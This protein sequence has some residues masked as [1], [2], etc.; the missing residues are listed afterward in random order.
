MAFTQIS[1]DGIKD[2]T[3]SSADLADQSVTLAKLPHG[4]SSNDG[5]FLRANNGADPTFETVTSIGGNTGVDFNDNVKVRFGTG[6]DLQIYHDGSNSRIH[7]GGTGV[8]AISGSE[9]HIQNA[10]QSENCA[11]FIQNGAVELYHD[12]SK[13]FETTSTGITVSGSDTTGSIIQGDFRLKTASG[14][15]HIVYDA[16]NSRINFADNISATFGD[17][18]DLQIY[19]DGSHSYVSAS[20]TGALKL[21]GNNND[22]VQIQPRSG[23]NSARFKPNNAV[24]L[25]YDNSKK[26]ETKSD[27]VLV[28]GELQAT[29]LDIN[30]NGH[31]DGTLQLTND[32][33]LGDNDEINV[34][35]SNDLK[36][37]HDGTN[38]I[39]NDANSAKIKIQRGGSD[40]W[41]LKST[42]LQGIDNQ[43]LMLGTSDD[44]Q[45][46]HDGSNSYILN[47]VGS[48]QLTIS[49]DN[50]LNLASRTGTEY[51]FRAY[52][53]GGA[54]LYYDNS[55]KF[56][57]K[58][59]GVQIT[60]ANPLVHIQ[61]T[62]NS[63]DAAIFLDAN[64]NHWLV[65]ADNSGSQ[66]TFSIK[67]GTAASSTHRLLI[68]SS[69]NVLIG[70]TSTGGQ[71]GLSILP[72]HDDG[73]CTL[74]FDRA[75][76]SDTSTV[77]NF[78]NNNSTVG[79]ITHGNSST[80]YNET[81]D[82]RLK[83]NATAISDGIARLKTLK[84]YRFNFK[85]DTSK[86]VDGFF[87]HEVTAVPEAVVGTKDQVDAD[88]NPVYQQIDKS[89]LVPLLTAAVQEAISKIEVLETEVA[90]LKGS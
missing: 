82:Y 30:G 36:I 63:G 18:N 40:V 52:T 84:P 67:S 79:S 44:L 37:Y 39:I 16:S 55:K 5:K 69:G 75:N 77:L 28:T 45:I 17:A 49:S 56:E 80:A 51:F 32:L 85:V 33:F 15:Q 35:S 74:I 76:T 31:I 42:G 20:G 83:E 29:T 34:G 81:S 2:G 89:K 53:N 60:D 86:T 50:A 90:A 48:G 23:Y 19:H 41:E 62:G 13:K 65:R 27:G 88:N 22:D 72:F 57:T 78:E 68:D 1:T 46:Y 71:G 6:N 9:V 12:N 3:I 43:K 58:S 59:D 21:L 70:T 8:L 38:N 66:N 26:L 73:A 4:T 64:A 54:E 10:A 87:A 25:Y 24:E 11:K 7:D 14:T 61:G 47:A